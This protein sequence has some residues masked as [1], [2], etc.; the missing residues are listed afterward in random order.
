MRDWVAEA[1]AEPW[2]DARH[3]ADVAEAGTLVRDLRTPA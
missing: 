1:L 2:R 3:E